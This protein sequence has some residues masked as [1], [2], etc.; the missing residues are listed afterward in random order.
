MSFIWWFN[1]L[2]IANTL[3]ICRTKGKIYFLFGI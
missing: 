2:V 3:G 1:G